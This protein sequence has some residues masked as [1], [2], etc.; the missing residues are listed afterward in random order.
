MVNVSVQLGDEAAARSDQSADEG[1]Q[2]GQGDQS[3]TPF[4]EFLRRFFENNGM[5]QTKRQVMA[6]G[7]G[8]IIDPAGYIVTNNH[9]VDGAHEVSVTLT[10]GRQIRP[11]S[12]AAT[13]RPIWRC[14]RSMPGIR[15]PMS[16]SAIPTRSRKA[17]G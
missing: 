6:L 9:V 7:S 12:S 1:D 16:P 15:C 13:P 14:S 4:D 5:P 10:D 3:A 2:G 8:F 11:R 17:I